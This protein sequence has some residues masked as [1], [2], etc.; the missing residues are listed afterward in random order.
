MGTLIEVIEGSTL[1]WEVGSLF[2]RKKQFPQVLINVTFKFEL[3]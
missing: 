2:S 1:L 3:K